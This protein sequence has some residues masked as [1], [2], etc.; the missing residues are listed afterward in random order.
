MSMPHSGAVSM[1]QSGAVSSRRKA[2]AAVAAALAAAAALFPAAPAEA[3]LAANPL[4]CAASASVQSGRGKSQFVD[5]GDGEVRLPRQGDVYWTGS[6]AKPAHQE[7][8]EVRMRVGFWSV[9][10]G[11][12]GTSPNPANQ[13]M[14]QGATVL[15]A[16]LRYVPPG[17][18]RVEGEHRATEGRCSGAVTVVLAGSAFTTVAALA[19][20]LLTVPLGLGL[21]RAGRPRPGRPRGRP[22]RGAVMGAL[23]GLTLAGVGLASFLI[24]S[25]S[26]LVGGL[27]LALLLGGIALGAFAP[28]RGATGDGPSGA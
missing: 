23:L 25:D 26:V 24:S 16:F 28:F 17:R 1:P 7:A 12:W 27:P 6:V 18:Y 13:L 22:V 14:R 21:F 2:A 19:A 15:P 11:A 10:V 5:S 9:T 8:G 4:G 20:T 3:D